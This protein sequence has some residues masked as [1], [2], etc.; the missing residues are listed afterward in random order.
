MY[1]QTK[2]Q[3]MAKKHRDNRPITAAR[4]QGAARLTGGRGVVSAGVFY[5]VS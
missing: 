4:P 1:D 3:I 2:E 5:F